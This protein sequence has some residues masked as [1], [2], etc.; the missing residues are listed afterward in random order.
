MG[1]VPLDILDFVPAKAAHGGEMIII[2]KKSL[3]R[4]PGS[5]IELT[6]F[7]ERDFKPEIE[8]LKQKLESAKQELE[9]AKQKLELLENEKQAM[10]QSNSWK[11]SRPIRKIAQLF[12]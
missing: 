10:L 12:R 9:S 6:A 1:Y 8:S 11:I 2:L 5:H 7:Y 4:L 3:P